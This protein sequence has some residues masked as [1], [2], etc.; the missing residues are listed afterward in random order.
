[1]RQVGTYCGLPERR[2]DVDSM[3]MRMC[4]RALVLV[5]V[6]DLHTHTRTSYA[7]LRVEVRFVFC[8]SPDFNYTQR[9]I[10]HFS[11]ITPG[12][13]GE[14]MVGAVA[15]TLRELDGTLVDR[16]DR[17]RWTLYK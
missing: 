5:Y 7:M 13:A 8:T 2:T 10:A 4:E 16:M 3:A 6:Y 1:M 17:R 12:C 15:L 14:T 9:G 11:H